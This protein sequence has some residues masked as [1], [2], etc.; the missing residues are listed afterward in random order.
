MQRER[1]ENEIGAEKEKDEVNTQQFDE[2]FSVWQGSEGESERGWWRWE[3]INSYG[4][5]GETVTNRET[6]AIT[7]SCAGGCC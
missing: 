1:K 4:G 2:R 5:E 6:K 3:A 7:L